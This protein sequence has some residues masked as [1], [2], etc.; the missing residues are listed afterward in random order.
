VHGSLSEVGFRPANVAERVALAKIVEELLDQAT[1]HGHLGLGQLRDAISRNQLKMADL[2]GLPELIGA[3]ALLA[4]DRRLAVAVDGVHRRGE[5]YLRG[6]QKG[7]SVLFGTRVG[8]VLVRYVMLPVGGGFLVPFAT[9]LIINELSHLARLL[10]LLPR[11]PPALRHHHHLELPSAGWV[12]AFSAL[13]FGLI[14]SA[15]VRAAALQGLRVV[16]LVL[17]AIFVQA[18][19][20]ILSRTLVQRVLRS[21]ALLGFGR[22]VI[23]P[24]VLAGVTYVPP[25]HVL[26]GGH[27]LPVAA[28]AFVAS[29]AALNSR[30]GVLVEEVVLDAFAHTLRRLQRDVLPGLYRLVLRAS[31]WFT[32]SIDQAIYAVDEWLRF[33]EGQRAS[34][35][36]F[37]AVLSL[38]WF[39]IAYLLRVLVN[40]FIEPTVNP[41]KH[42]PTVTVAAKVMWATVGPWLHGVL[43]PL[44][45]PLR[46]GTLTAV[47][48]GILPGFFGFLV[49]E[50]K[51]NYKL[52][53]ATRA[54]KIRPVPIG[55]HGETMGAL[56]KPGLHSGTVPK[57]WAK[58][59]RAARK[60]DGSVEKHRE[61]MHEIEEAV[62]RFVDRELS[63][64]L[65]ESPRWEGAVHVA[66]V[67]TASNRVRVDLARSG[68]DGAEGEACTLA[69]E[70]QSGWLVA[71]VARAGWAGTLTGDERVLFENALGGLYHRA[72]VDFVREQ[73]EAAL[74][75]GSKYD[76]ADEGLVVWPSGW[77]T[78]L[79]YD[80]EAEPRLTAKVRG[81]PPAEP[82]PAIDRAALFFREQAISW[83]AWAEAWS[84]EPRRLVQGASLLPRP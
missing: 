31:R 59:R 5:L 67:R 47:A 12:V 41:I 74:P 49:W 15:P 23:K 61:A 26:L 81:G 78:E 38:F 33:R 40:L 24:A 9:P 32:D 65:A 76:I 50:L 80:L 66:R 68:R 27:A 46:A 56:L 14:H 43:G 53:R 52:Y 1:A 28:F 3:D 62:E 60:G 17:T 13:L 70:E 4:A 30:T 37:K 21:R 6:L 73:I 16:G 84:G 82:P 36:A 19:I 42:F 54:P 71:R 25:L 35:L 20:W 72:G 57:L 22:F 69:F 18:P 2:S 79:V 55:H 7:S 39:V 48:M 8:R 64:L 29:S 44:L 51:E 77:A 58:L 63:A 10:H 75:A 11:E 34:A 45:G 83:A